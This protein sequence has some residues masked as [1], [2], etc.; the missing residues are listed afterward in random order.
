MIVH[1]RFPLGRHTEFE[2]GYSEKRNCKCVDSLDTLIGYDVWVRFYLH[3]VPGRIV[4]LPAN[5]FRSL[6][7][8]RHIRLTSVIAN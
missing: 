4:S 8:F 6:R 3:I 2:R 1:H 5:L 7:L